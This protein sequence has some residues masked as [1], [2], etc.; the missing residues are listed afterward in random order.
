MLI[1]EIHYA[2]RFV[3]THQLYTVNCDAVQFVQC[4]ICISYNTTLL[5]L[6]ILKNSLVS[7]TTGKPNV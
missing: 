6:S 7:S 3:N 4:I 5:V 2:I 1:V